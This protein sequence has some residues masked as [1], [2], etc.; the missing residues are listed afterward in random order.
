MLK[1]KNIGFTLLGGLIFALS[2]CTSSKSEKNVADNLYFADVVYDLNEFQIEFSR[3]VIKT[4]YLEDSLRGKDSLKDLKFHYASVL[5]FKKKTIDSLYKTLPTV[6]WGKSP[7]KVLDTMVYKNSTNIFYGDSEVD[8][9]IKTTLI[10]YVVILKTLQKDI[11]DIRKEIESKRPGEKKEKIDCQNCKTLNSEDAINK[12]KNFS[13]LYLETENQF[14]ITYRELACSSFAIELINV[15]KV[16]NN[17]YKV[18]I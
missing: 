12:V 13:E 16:A 2:S 3:K 8:D 18:R 17:N 14:L 10:K 7:F 6:F 11:S 1:V 4:Y 9:D 15:R 5:Y